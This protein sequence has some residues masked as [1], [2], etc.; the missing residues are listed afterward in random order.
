MDRP[1][2]F[3][4]PTVLVDTTPDMKVQREEIFGPVLTARPFDDLEELAREA[5]DSAYG[6]GAGVWTQNVSTLHK[7]AKMLKAGTIYSNTYNVYDAALPFG[8]YKQ[9]GWGREMGEEVLQAYT[10]VKSVV[11]EL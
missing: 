6:L 4:E 8:G 3:V 5:N 1:G 11:L 9:S 10:Q 7:M 2:W